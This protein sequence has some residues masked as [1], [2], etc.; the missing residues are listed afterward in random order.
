MP[1]THW[2]RHLCRVPHRGGDCALRGR[3]DGF[4][5]AGIIGDDVAL[6]RPVGH[7]GVGALQVSEVRGS[8]RGRAVGGGSAAARVPM[9]TGP[10][11]PATR[12]RRSAGYGQANRRTTP[13]LRRSTSIKGPGLESQG[14]VVHG[15][16]SPHPAPCRGDYPLHCAAARGSGV[17][18]SLKAGVP[19][20]VTPAAHGEGPSEGCRCSRPHPEHGM[21]MRTP[22]VPIP[23]RDSAPPP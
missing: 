22:G 23:R 15:H 6:G 17:R 18:Q 5:V 3:P 16:G 10:S 4:P 21:S 9:R 8:L 11:P 7:R 13:S 20:S 2:T 1:R 19:V 12:S 14:E